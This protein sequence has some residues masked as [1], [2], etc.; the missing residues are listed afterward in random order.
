MSNPQHIGDLIFPS[1][2]G[3]LEIWTELPSGRFNTPFTKATLHLAHEAF[4]AI[5]HFAQEYV[6]LIKFLPVR[7]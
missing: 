7:L 5:P 3:H 2:F 4:T 1:H 6:A